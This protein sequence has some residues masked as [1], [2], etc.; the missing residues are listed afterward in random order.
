MIATDAVLPRYCLADTLILG[1]G[2]P[3]LG[4][5]GFGPELI[6]YL[7]AHAALGEGVLAL[8]SGMGVSRIL[9]DVA[10]ARGGPRRI[11]VADAMRLGESSGTV[12]LRT[13][14]EI[15]ATR[16][17]AISAHQEPASCLLRELGELS[18][19]EVLLLTVEPEC[20]PSEVSPGLSAAVRAAIPRACELLGERLP[21]LFAGTSPAGTG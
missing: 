9:F 1:C 16:A 19:V 20:M 2:N 18:G 11:V 7:D 3:L 10:L 5:D 14:D 15:P 21:L 4:D 13:L 17:R 6:A 12:S 8:D